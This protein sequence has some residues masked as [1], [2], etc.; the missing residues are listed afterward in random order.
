MEVETVEKNAAAIE[1]N[2][3]RVF[4]NH[5]RHFWRDRGETEPLPPL[6]WVLEEEGVPVSMMSVCGYRL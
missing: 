5:E 2:L 1:E 6:R 4:T 3:R